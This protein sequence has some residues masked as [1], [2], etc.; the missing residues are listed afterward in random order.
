MKRAEERERLLRSRLYRTHTVVLTWKRVGSAL[1][2]DFLD[3][4]SRLPLTRQRIYRDPATIMGLV[5]RSATP[6]GSGPRATLFHKALE[7]GR[8]EI[9]LEVSREQY[10]RLRT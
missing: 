9:E 2:V 3:P 10:E 6:V 5:D 4:R 7:I 1:L 8:G